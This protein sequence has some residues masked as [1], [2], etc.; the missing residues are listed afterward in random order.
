MD[1]DVRVL[2]EAKSLTQAQLGKA[3]G[4]SRQSV[5]SIEKGKYDPSLPLAIAIARFFG[6]AV[7]E[8]FHA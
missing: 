4:V 3:L 8:I 5:S 1:N 6:R 7:E 2:R